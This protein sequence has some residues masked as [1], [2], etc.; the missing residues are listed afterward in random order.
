LTAANAWCLEGVTAAF[1]ELQRYGIDSN[2]VKFIALDVGAKQM[3]KWRYVA[4]ER[5]LSAQRTAF[6]IT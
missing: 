1:E 3:L 5:S 6:A 2:G 4:V